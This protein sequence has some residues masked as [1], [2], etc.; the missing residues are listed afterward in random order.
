MQKKNNRKPVVLRM[1]GELWLYFE[2]CRWLIGMHNREFA[3]DSYC[4]C[5][6]G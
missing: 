2:N 4:L 6:L 1:P 5:V 3:G